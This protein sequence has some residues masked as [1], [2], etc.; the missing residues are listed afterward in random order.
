MEE[1]VKMAKVEDLFQELAKVVAENFVATYEV[2]EGN[3]LV[4]KIPNGQKFQITVE[5]K[6]D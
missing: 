2:N 4:M 6:V 1:Q 3:V 5:E